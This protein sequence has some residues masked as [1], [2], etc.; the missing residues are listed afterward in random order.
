MNPN[1]I[2]KNLSDGPRKSLV[3]C[4]SCLLGVL[5]NPWVRNP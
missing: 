4:D 5:R 2:L 1:V 3:P